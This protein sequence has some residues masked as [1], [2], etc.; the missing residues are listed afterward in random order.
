MNEEQVGILVTA[1]NMA[2]G[3][4]NQV[5]GELSGLGTAAS[6]AGG[7]LGR[8]GSIGNALSGP[9]GHARGAISNLTSSLGLVG[10]SG[11][12]L[13]VGGLL[14]ASIDQTQQ[15]G[16]GVEK[17]RAI[18]GM[19]VETSSALIAVAEKYGVDTQALTKFA[20]QYEKAVGKLAE[21]QAK[22]G[23]IAK[24]AALQQLEAEKLH[25]QAAGDSI[26][27]IDKQISEQKAL[28]ALAAKSAGPAGGMNKLQ[29][30]QKQYG[31]VLTD[32]AGRALSFQDT[33]LNLADAEQKAATVSEKA[34]LAA[35][36]SSIGMSRSLT[37]LAPLLSLGRNGILQAEQ[38]AKDLG[39]TLDAQ[40]A[41]S[42]A[43]Y[44][45]AQRGLGE[46]THALELQIGIGVMP[47][48]TKFETG[49]TGFLEHG[50]GQ[51]IAGFFKGA[52]DF[53]S[54]FADAL[55]QVLPLFGQ[56]V[57]AF[58]G[59]P[60][61][62]R[63]ILVGGFVAQKA[64]SMLFGSG[65]LQWARGLLG[66]LGGG[67]G[68]VGAIT[69][70]LAGAQPVNVMNWPPGLGLGGGGLASGISGA[71]EQGAAKGLG[72]IASLMAKIPGLGGVMSG[73]GILATVLPFVPA[74]IATVIASDLFN[75]YMD[76]QRQLHQ[77]EADV[78]K[79]ATDWRAKASVAQLAIMLGANRDRV[80]TLRNRG[81]VLPSWLPI[82]RASLYS[83]TPGVLAPEVLEELRRGDRCAQAP[84]RRCEAL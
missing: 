74:I 60:A 48:L 31:V 6:G 69:G 29:A 10:L 78:E 66:G 56:L 55:S 34:R 23:A 30:L 33:L 21:T 15:F 42:L 70:A 81:L 68:P 1:R 22:A 14:K 49:I 11:A 26:K 82:L 67:R 18:T 32:S 75:G 41:G 19:S 5:K 64:S 47:V 37:T 59:L 73:G 72:P 50:G 65:P 77:Q 63:D 8:L 79:R 25:L 12:L 28:D 7:H 53:A 44:V 52:A 84:A 54:T 57:G 35:L 38:A 16:L 24:S 76:Q 43:K 83:P 80:R 46:A 3:V 36:A 45:A 62:L 40:S 39:M 71:V 58:Q 13:G 27:A 20:G 4:L 9:L 51:Q 61:P 2:T 17:L